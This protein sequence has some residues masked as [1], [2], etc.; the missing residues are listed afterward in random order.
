MI[1]DRIN[2]LV[3]ELLS[4]NNVFKNGVYYTT[5]EEF[6]N[7]GLETNKT[8]FFYI[9]HID[10]GGFKVKPRNTFHEVSTKLRLVAQLSTDYCAEQAVKSLLSQL[11]DICDTYIQ[12]DSFDI[13]R[14]RIYITEYDEEYKRLNYNLVSIDFTLIEENLFVN[15][16]PICADDE[17]ND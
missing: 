15:C 11:T 2:L 6:V 7:N 4:T 8:D 13:D 16:K 10:K 12:I 9:R 17:S 1:I 14:Q 3:D 5:V